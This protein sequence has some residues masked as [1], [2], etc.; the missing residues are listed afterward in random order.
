MVK[1]AVLETAEVLA[2]AV[3][4]SEPLLLPEAG[5]MV[6]HDILFDT[7]QLTL[8][9]I[10]TACDSPAAEKLNVEDPTVS[11]DGIAS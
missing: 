8:E 7:V 9:V 2:V 11:D 1:S 3:I 6:I 4:L 10:E 5:V